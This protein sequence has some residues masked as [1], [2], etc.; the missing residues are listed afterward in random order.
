MSVH[1]AETKPDSFQLMRLVFRAVVTVVQKL[2][3][4]VFSKYLL[5]YH[6]SNFNQNLNLALALVFMLK[7]GSRS[8][9]LS[10]LKCT[11]PSEKESQFCFSTFGDFSKLFDL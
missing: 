10:T 4:N 6:P 1:K 9:A 2:S 3:L 7:D 8:L 11:V 5:L